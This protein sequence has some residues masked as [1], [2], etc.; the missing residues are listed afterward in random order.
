IQV[1]FATGLTE[2]DKQSFSVYPNPAESKI[3]IQM[4]HNINKAFV[5][6]EN[7]LG[8]Q[9]IEKHIH[10]KTGEIDVSHLKP[11]IYFINLNTEK[12]KLVKKVIIK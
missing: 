11:G 6:M 1:S 5:K 8:K 7:A 4:S 9:L 10:S 2:P 12:G 3:N